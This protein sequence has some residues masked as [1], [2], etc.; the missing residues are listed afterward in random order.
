MVMGVYVLLAGLVAGLLLGP[1]VLGQFKP[2]T[3]QHWFPNPTLL[4][5]KR[6]EIRQSRKILEQ[7]DVTFVALEEFD[8]QRQPEM[9]AIEAGLSQSRHM[10]GIM[11]ALLLAMLMSLAAM[12]LT[13]RHSRLF[14]RLHLGAHV[15]LACWLCLFV[16]QPDWLVMLPGMVIVLAL[17]AVLVICL[18]P[19]RRKP[20][21]Q[22]ESDIA[23]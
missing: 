4:K 9:D 16:A 10:Q 7:T 14:A 2:R 8:Q 12:N 22:P 3:Y 20:T 19:S 17:L 13:D 15:L 1:M 11:H 23:Q 5:A 21:P 6:D 18:I